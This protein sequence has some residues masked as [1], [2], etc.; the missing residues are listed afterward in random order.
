MC[1]LS[2]CCTEVRQQPVSLI[3]GETLLMHVLRAS[4]GLLNIGFKTD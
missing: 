2:E 3:P 4:L 1:M